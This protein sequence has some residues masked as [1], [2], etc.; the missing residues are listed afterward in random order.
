MARSS[1]NQQNLAASTKTANI[2]AGDI[3]EFVE[4][5]S[6]VTIY[7]SP[8]AA[9]V[10]LSAFADSDVLIDDKEL[11]SIRATSQL[12][13][14]DDIVDQFDVAAGSRLSLTLRETAA[15]ATT[16]VVLAVDVQP[17]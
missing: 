4:E 10:R 15:V 5:D 11:V 13:I 16:D 9:G 6:R 1:F 12:V 8:N 17:L 7:A 2:L 14:P 3:N